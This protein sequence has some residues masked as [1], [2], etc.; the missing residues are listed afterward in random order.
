METLFIIIV[1]LLVS[2]F[3]LGKLNK[4]ISVLYFHL[5]KKILLI[6]EDT[7]AYRKWKIMEREAE[8]K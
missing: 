6:I 1:F 2:D 7:K 4:P 5:R 3:L 8:V